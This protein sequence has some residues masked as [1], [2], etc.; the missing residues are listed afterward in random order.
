MKDRIIALTCCMILLSQCLYGANIIIADKE[1]KTPVSSAIVTVFL[2]GG[3]RC[4][5]E[6]NV[7]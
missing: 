5:V 3:I 6:S 2:G 4:T 7:R 1:S